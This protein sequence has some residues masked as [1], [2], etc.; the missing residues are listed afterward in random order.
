M[1]FGAAILL[2]FSVFFSFGQILPDSIILQKSKQNAI[3]FYDRVMEG[4]LHIYN[5]T[6][7][8][9]YR[10]LQD[11][12]PFFL[13][14]EWTNGNILYDGE[15]F[16]NMPMLYDIEKDLVIISYYFKGIKMK[17]N[18]AR[19]QE[20]IFNG[21]RFVNL[22]QTTDSIEMSGGFYDELYRGKTT[23]MCSRNKKY[24]ENKVETQLFQGFKE[25][26]QYYLFINGKFR[27]VS[28]K[29]SVLNLLADRKKELKT[30]IRKN[31]LFV[32]DRESSITRVAEYYDS[33]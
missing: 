4:N 3:A 26:T 33:L 18:S 11:E 23:V 1:R 28:T 27:K 5:G 14:D 29:Q 19:V 22:K 32:L 21:H 2:L 15:W 25:T 10:P 31:R 30:F 6:E 7:Y 8:L 17:L 20:F 13:T 24:F 16:T 12:H 9:P